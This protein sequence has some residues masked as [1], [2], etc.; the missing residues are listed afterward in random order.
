MRQIP[1]LCLT[2]FACTATSVSGVLSGGVS[3][4]ATAPM[5][6]AAAAS[7]TLTVAIP[8]DVNNFDPST[9][10]L[11]LF[12]ATFKPLIFSYLVKFGPTLNIEPDLATSWTVNSNAT[13]FTFYKDPVRGRLPKRC[14]GD[15]TSRLQALSSTR[16]TPPRCWHRISL[17]CPNGA[18]S[19][20]APCR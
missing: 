12:D 7:S 11:N 17:E 8:G 15:R 9:E 13:V 3:V 6:K 16:S 20:A 19:T 10:Q 2:V 18:S 14:T 4:A 5:A 1:K